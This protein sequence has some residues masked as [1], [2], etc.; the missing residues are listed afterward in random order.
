MTLKKNTHTHTKRGL[1]YAPP[2]AGGE[3]VGVDTEPKWPPALPLT[4]SGNLKSFALL[5]REGKWRSLTLLLPITFGVLLRG[6]GVNG[7]L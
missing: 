2:S 1:L 3:K 7:G 4:L 6:R 5:S